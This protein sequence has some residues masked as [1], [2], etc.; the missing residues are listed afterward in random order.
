[1]GR[2]HSNR[3]FDTRVYQVEFPDG[4]T[5]KFA[6]NIIAQNLYSQLG[7]E[8]RQHLL[9]DEIIDYEVTDEA[10]DNNNRFQISHNGNIHPSHP[11]NY[12]Q[13]SR[14]HTP[15]KLNLLSQGAWRI[16]LLLDG[17][18]LLP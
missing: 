11:G 5:Q 2:G 14:K 17:G 12:S 15:Y 18:Y 10:F 7:N 9:L 3:I 6:A 4:H 16:M 8:R 1:M 13:T